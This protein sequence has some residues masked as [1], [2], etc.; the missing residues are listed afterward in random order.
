MKVLKFQIGQFF[1]VVGVIMVALFFVTGNGGHPQY[2]LFFGGAL[3]VGA[4]ISLMMRNRPPSPGESAR[5][6]RVR[7]ARQKARDR[8]ER[9]RQQLKERRER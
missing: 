7:Q 6:R 4:G 8:R 5:F 1:L 3:I 2:L 9:K